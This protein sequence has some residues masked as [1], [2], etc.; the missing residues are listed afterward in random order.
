[1]YDVIIVGA[2]FAGLAVASQLDGYRVLLLDK[3]PIGT[4]QTSACGTAL[5]VLQYW[6]LQDSV[7]QS[8][9][10]LVLHTKRKAYEFL[11]PFLWCTFDYEQLCSQLFDMAGAEFIQASVRG[12]RDGWVETDRGRFSARCIVDASG[13]RAIL[14]SSLSAGFSQSKAMNFGIETIRPTSALHDSEGLHFWYDADFFKAGVGWV[15]PRGEETSYGVGSYRGAKPLN[16]LLKQFA[17]RFNIAPDGIHG[18][19]FPSSLRKATVGPIFLVGDAAGMCLGLIGE[20]IRPALFFGENC[21]RILRRVL[22]DELSLREGLAEYDAFVE[23]RRY[24]FTIFSGIENVLT[25]VPA[26][27][28]DRIA[29]IIQRE[30]VRHWVFDNYWKLTKEWTACIEHTL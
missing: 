13:W 9:D 27:W 21:G 26:R 7:L 3:A 12:Y 15:F 30:R 10:R 1:M 4:H 24:F 11:A 8:H 6:G 18:T 5:P 2:S 17:R 14:A 19:Y 25:R 29:M 20:G 23:G 16:H 28:V 22:A